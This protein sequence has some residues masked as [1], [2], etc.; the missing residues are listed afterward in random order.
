LLALDH[1]EF[2]EELVISTENLA[3]LCK[4]SVE[5]YRSAPRIPWGD[6]QQLVE[7]GADVG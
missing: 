5:L 2:P 7:G 4:Q 3:G 1:A 6:F